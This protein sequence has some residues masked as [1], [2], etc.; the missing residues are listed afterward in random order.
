LVAQI[1]IY[2]HDDVWSGPVVIAR[3]ARLRF[4]SIGLMAIRVTVDN[5]ARV[6]V[7]LALALTFLH[8]VASRARTSDLALT[9]VFAVALLLLE[10]LCDGANLGEAR[11]VANLVRPEKRFIHG[12]V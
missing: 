9:F 11:R 3:R 12:D 5:A 2:L 1:L 8:N 7:V 6:V 10:L 4:L